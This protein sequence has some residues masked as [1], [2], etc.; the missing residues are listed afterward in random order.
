MTAP[1]TR[2]LA[3]P[4]PRHESPSRVQLA[5]PTINPELH[6]DRVIKSNFSK[7]VQ[8]RILSRLHDARLR[9]LRK[10]T[11][12]LDLNPDQL[13]C[14]QVIFDK[15]RK[16]WKVSSRAPRL[17][18]LPSGKYELVDPRHAL[19]KMSGPGLAT[20]GQD[21]HLSNLSA[22]RIHALLDNLLIIINKLYDAHIAYTP[23][24]RTLRVV[25]KE[26]DGPLWPFVET[27]D[28]TKH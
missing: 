2:R 8:L 27:F 25:V 23:D 4:R 24:I 1:P 7:L 28:F 14:A 11:R 26:S 16:I 20:C 15:L 5:R 6:P 18:H 12:S 10:R 19:W 17:L 9:E 13:R 22:E 3:C 21:I